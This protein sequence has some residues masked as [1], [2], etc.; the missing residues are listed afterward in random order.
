MFCSAH[1]SITAGGA[2]GYNHAELRVS[3]PVR[4]DFTRVYV[5]IEAPAGCT[6]LRDT[7]TWLETM[8]LLRH[9]YQEII[10]IGRKHGA[11]WP[12]RAFRLQ[13]YPP[14]DPL[15]LSLSFSAFPCRPRV[16]EP[17]I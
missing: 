12:P 13:I 5:H 1:R 6:V 10:V 2:A 7:G 11:A 17:S 14:W 4:L 3:S 9:R 8:G 16:A 15:S